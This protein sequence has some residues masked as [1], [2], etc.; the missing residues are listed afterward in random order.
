MLDQQYRRKVRQ[1]KLDAL[2][3]IQLHRQQIDK[4]QQRNRFVESL[5][6]AV[7]VFYLTPRLLARGTVG[8][9]LVDN[10]GEILAAILLVLAILKLVNKWQDNEIKHSI[11]LR[12][13]RTIVYE[14]DRL[15]ERRI[16]SPDVIDQFLSRVKDISDEDE[17][18]LPENKT[19]LKEKQK[20]YRKALMEL[21]PG[22]TNLCYACNANPLYFTPG[23]CKTCG[24]TP[25][26][27]EKNKVH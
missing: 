26:D 1:K 27:S 22:D 21:S 19:S 13:N 24:G 3:A 4:L 16:T 11:L 6:I 10:I 18:L 14:S 20:A 2:Y 25:A 15:L 9:G 12:R 17:A 8:E 23:N 5:S 7:P